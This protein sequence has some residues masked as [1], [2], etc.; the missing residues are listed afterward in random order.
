MS[1][2]VNFTCLEY[3]VSINPLC[4]YQ[5]NPGGG[6]GGARGGDLTFLQKKMSNATPSGENSCAKFPT[7]GMKLYS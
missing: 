5:C 2:F 6:G 7:P 1:K 4:T 3:I